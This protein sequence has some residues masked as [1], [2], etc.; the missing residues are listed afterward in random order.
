M[1]ATFIPFGGGGAGGGPLFL[2]VSTVAGPYAVGPSDYTILAD[3]TA[4]PMTVT[5]PPVSTQRK[6][7]L[8]VKKVD[9]TANAVTVAASGADTIDGAPTFDLVLQYESVALQAPDVGA[10]WAVI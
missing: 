9:G 5:L 8:N 4:G 10:D 6:R 2:G 1:R 3:A 7:L